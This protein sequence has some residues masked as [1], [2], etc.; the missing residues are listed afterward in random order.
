MR[1]SRQRHAAL[2]V[3]ADPEAAAQRRGGARIALQPQELLA[4]LDD[5]ELMVVSPLAA[6]GPHQLV[7]PVELAGLLQKDAAVVVVVGGPGN[8][9][10]EGG[11]AV[12]GVG[13]QGEGF[14]LLEIH[15]RT[16]PRSAI[17]RS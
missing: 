9:L 8:Q 3:E 13:G 6:P 15:R 5:L 14:Q 10:G 12:G 11:P 1:A 2:M 17:L 16:I 7:D 4:P